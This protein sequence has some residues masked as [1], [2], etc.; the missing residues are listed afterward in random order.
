MP[1]W[2][3]TRP[4]ITYTNEDGMVSPGQK[5]TSQTYTPGK[6][7]ILSTLGNIGN[8]ALAPWVQAYG[9]NMNYAIRQQELKMQQDMADMEFQKYLMQI[10]QKEMQPDLQT[11]LSGLGQSNLPP[12]T[13]LSYKTPVGPL[14]IPL[15]REYTQGET[16]DITAAESIGGQIEKLKNILD[17][18]RSTKDQ[19]Y[20]SLPFGGFNEGG[21]R[22]ATIKKDVS[23]RLLRLRSGAAINEQEYKRFI[24]LLPV[25]WRN[26]KVD[27]EQLNT[28]RK[29]FQSI[30]GRIKSGA[31]WDNTKKSFIGGE[32]PKQFSREEILAE[33]ERRKKNAK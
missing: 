28:F 33:I 3:D 21:Q 16:K 8:A 31:Q 23:D 20:G 25:V 10:N 26:D 9:G 24:D 15:N 14:T 1:Q 4:S 7:G 12:G 32:Q 5:G 18:S 19:F 13:T 27:L 11:V 17:S 2:F 22:F 30:E 29:E 6:P